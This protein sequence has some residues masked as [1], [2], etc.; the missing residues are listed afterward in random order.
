MVAEKTHY[1]A[2]YYR[3]LIRKYGC[4]AR[5]CDYGSSASQFAKFKILMECTDFSKKSILDIGCGYA[6]FAGF[7]AEQV[8]DFEYSGIELCPEM[9]E[10]A[11]K[12][13]PWAIIM[14]G[15]FV[16]IECSAADIVTANGIFYLLGE[17]AKS[18]MHQIIV[19]M[20]RLANEVVAFNSLSSWRV[21]KEDG[22][23]YADPLETLLFC[24]K[25]TP[26]V[27]LRHDYHPG[28]FTIYMYKGQNN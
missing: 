2:H 10:I 19:K 21:N 20:W 8:T 26:W 23:Y 16:D 1:I 25:L 4:D 12:N 3:D 17:R 27:V 6:A 11:R 18:L 9:V 7:L 22:E 13:I 15:D 24:R 14:E 5:A 28:D